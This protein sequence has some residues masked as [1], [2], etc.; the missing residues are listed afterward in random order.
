MAYVVPTE[1]TW[2]SQVWRGSDIFH[3]ISIYLHRYK[4]TNYFLFEVWTTQIY[5]LFKSYTHFCL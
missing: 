4:Y 1:G 5:Y 2:R 3:Y